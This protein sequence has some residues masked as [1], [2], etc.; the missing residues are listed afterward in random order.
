MA[1]RHQHAGPRRGI[2][3]RLED[4]MVDTLSKHS[5]PNVY[6]HWGA[7]ESGKSRAANN[8]AIRLQEQGRLVILRHGYDFTFKKDL[9][10]WLGLSIGIPEDRSSDKISTFFPADRPTVLILDHAEFLLKQYGEKDL[11]NTLDTMGIPVLI[12][13]GSWERAIDLRKQGC[14]LLGEPGLGRWTPQELDDL[15]ETFPDRLKRKVETSKPEL[16][17]CALLARSPGILVFESHDEIKP[18]M[19]RAKLIAAEWENGIR[20]LN[21]EDMKE[22]TGR[23]PDWNGTFHWDEIK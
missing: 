15:Y 3:S 12:L 6:V 17:E 13:A 23:F 18:N 4:V 10:S 14:L 21:G 8:A 19:H 16:R 11:V 7:Y 5:L 2:H 22:I 1:E 20:A 9:R